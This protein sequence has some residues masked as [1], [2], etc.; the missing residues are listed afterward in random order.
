MAL[1]LSVD[2]KGAPMLI[3]K[4]VRMFVVLGMAG[5]ALC[6]TAAFGLPQMAQAAEGDVCALYYRTPGTHQYTLVIQKGAAPNSEYGNLVK[7]YTGIVCKKGSSA[8]NDGAAQPPENCRCG[9]PESDY[10]MSVTKVVVADAIAPHKFSFSYFD[11]LVDIDL[12][13]L[14]TSRMASMAYMFSG[15]DDLKKLDLRTFDTSRVTTMK[16]M[17]GSFSPLVCLYGQGHQA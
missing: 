11:H 6:L 8:N 9:L 15:C 13:L 3:A 1:S 12:A 14:D 16:H 4:R 2:D 7:V 10:N 5:I 17:F